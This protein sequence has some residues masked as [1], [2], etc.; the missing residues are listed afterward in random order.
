[1]V[2]YIHFG[3]SEL[4]YKVYTTVICRNVYK[5]QI[6]SPVT[7][8][9]LDVTWPSAGRAYISRLST[10]LNKT[11]TKHLW[12]A[13]EKRCGKMFDIKVWCDLHNWAPRT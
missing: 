11:T 1:M 4:Q 2:N 7:V 8:F 13:V 3:I 10:T 9:F 6:Y 12:V 5:W